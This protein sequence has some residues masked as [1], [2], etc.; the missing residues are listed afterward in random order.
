MF[1]C[2]VC[3][4]ELPDGTADC[5]HCRVH[6]EP[7][8]KFNPGAVVKIKIE[9]DMY[10]NHVVDSYFNHEINMRM[11]RLNER[12]AMPIWR[13]DWLE[14]VSDDEIDRVNKTGLLTPRRS[15]GFEHPIMKVVNA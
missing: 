13:E 9:D 3:G 12:M 11:Y 4:T 15:G 14:P 5:T 2:K 6:Q 7:L 8:A 10:Y 1:K